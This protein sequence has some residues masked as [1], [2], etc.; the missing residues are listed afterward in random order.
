MGAPGSSQEAPWGEGACLSWSREPGAAGPFTTEGPRLMRGLSQHP[1]LGTFPASGEPVRSLH[2]RHVLA[3][4]VFPFLP[5]KPAC[6]KPDSRPCPRGPAS[7][8][9]DSS[10]LHLHG[11]SLVCPC[12][13]KQSQE[14]R[15]L[16]GLPA[17]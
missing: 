1:R 4:P 8:V 15:I 12:C 9:G 3:A 13:Q 17:G 16:L 14:R 7:A 6:S 5:R 2:Q 11:L 10:C